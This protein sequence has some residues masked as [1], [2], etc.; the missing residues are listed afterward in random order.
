MDFLKGLVENIDGYSEGARFLIKSGDWKSIVDTTVGE[1][2][3]VDP[4]YRVAIE[5]AL[6]EASGYVIV[7]SIDNAYAAIDYLKKHQ[8]GKATFIC[9]DRLPKLMDHRPLFDG[10]RHRW[11]GEQSR[12]YRRA[13]QGAVPRPCWMIRWSSPMPALRANWS[14]ESKGMRCV[15]LEGEIVTSK[16]SC[17]VEAS[18]RTKG[19]HIGGRSQ[20]EEMAEEIRGLERQRERL[21]AEVEQKN[22]ELV[23]Y[24]RETT[25]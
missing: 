20:L 22:D 9:L 25:A 11:M 17:G 13:V 3:T 24:R 21:L 6:G 16:G 14:E 12:A 18:V 4:R 19:G 2:A 5:S 7:E 15:T 8:K 23:K 1:A 10:P